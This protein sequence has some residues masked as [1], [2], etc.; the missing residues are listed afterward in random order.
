M[1]YC[2]RFHGILGQNLSLT[3]QWCLKFLYLG[4]ASH[5]K[6][7]IEFQDKRAER[8]LLAKHLFAPKVGGEPLLKVKVEDQFLLMA[9]FVISYSGVKVKMWVMRAL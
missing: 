7:E 4:K 6:P 8:R 1:W 3:V 9:S 2:D 5:F